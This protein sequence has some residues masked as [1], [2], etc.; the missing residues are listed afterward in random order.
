MIDYKEVFLTKFPSY[1]SS[2]TYSIG[3]LYENQAKLIT[4]AFPTYMTQLLFEFCGDLS[5]TQSKKKTTQITKRS[6][7]NAG[8]GEWI[9]IFQLPS[10]QTKREVK[11]FKVDLHPHT[12]YEIFHLSPKEILKDDIRIEDIWHNK[13]SALEMIDQLAHSTRGEEMIQI[14]ETHFLQQMLQA[15]PPRNYT[16]LLSRQHSNLTTLSQELGYSQRW[17]QMQYKEIFGL[18]FKE[19]QNNMRFLQVLEAI[20]TLAKSKQT[21]NLSLLALQFGYYDQSHFIK[22]FKHYTGFTPN[23]YIQKKFSA[24]IP[25]HW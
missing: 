18:S 5:T 10:S 25:F 4:R 17:V 12:L 2:Y 16:T 9:D 6:Y 11:N 3:S 7:V 23:I 20:N 1:I 14:F 21:I 24:H 15:K 22:E 13:K 8:I 19:L